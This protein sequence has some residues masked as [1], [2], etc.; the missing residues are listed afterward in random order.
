MERRAAFEVVDR[1]EEALCEYTGAP[2]AVTVDSCTN[3]IFLCL[4]WTRFWVKRDLDD[5]GP[6]MVDLPKHTYIGV[7]QAA[8][9]AGVNVRF[10]DREWSGSY[11]LE[12][13]SI[14]DSAKEF[15]RGMYEPG[16]TT[17]VSFQAGKLLPIGRGGAI[18]HDTPEADEWFRKARLDGRIEGADYKD[19]TFQNPGFHCYMTPPDA[20][21]GLWLLTYLEDDDQG[22][23]TEYPDLSVATWT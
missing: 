12:P 1:F 8:L 7:P 15:Y 19:P 11:R 10:L 6:I 17:C 2:Y 4:A 20:A 5:D 13:T 18:L 9:N 16:N 14:I 23:W 3:A 21:R 22:D